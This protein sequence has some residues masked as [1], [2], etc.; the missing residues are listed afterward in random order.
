[1]LVACG[2]C[3]RCEYWINNVCLPILVGYT[4]DT[5]IRIRMGVDTALDTVLDAVCELD[6]DGSTTVKN[7]LSH[8][9]FFIL[10]SLFFILLFFFLYSF[11]LFFYSLFFFLFSFFSI[12]F[13]LGKSRYERDLNT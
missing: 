9:F 5:S 12:Y 8:F 11:S 4:A 2:I 6:G 3:I 13:F 1:M 10:F 7:I